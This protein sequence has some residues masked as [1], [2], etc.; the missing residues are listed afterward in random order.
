MDPNMTCHPT[1]GD[2]LVCYIFVADKSL[3]INL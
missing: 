3:E 1:D 2:L